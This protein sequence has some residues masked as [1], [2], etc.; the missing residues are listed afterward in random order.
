MKVVD[1]LKHRGE[2][3]TKHHL[4]IKELMSP[5]IRDYWSDLVNKA[6][7]SPIL[8]WFRDHSM[9]PAVNEG[10]KPTDQESFNLSDEALATFNELHEKLDQ[11][12]HVGD[13]VHIEQERINSFGQVTEDMQ[14]IHTDP[15]RAA[16][17][18]PFKTTIAHGFLTLSMLSKMTD[19]VDA[20]N[21]LFPAAR[22][23]VNVGLNQVRFPYPV[24][25]GNK[26]RTRSKLLK[27]TPIKKGIEVERELKVEID[28]V[29]RPGCVVISVVRLY[30]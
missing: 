9:V 2:S 27:V 21:P 7:E 19:S 6:N 14:W 4:E 5:A 11:E 15:E 8:H 23:V 20:D 25:A 17:E 28:G 22:L 24:K 1:I 26:I 13:W 18:S 12:I 16:E 10:V 30:F 29:R 3:L